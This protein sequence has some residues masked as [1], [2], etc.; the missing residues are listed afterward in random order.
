MATQKV[1]ARAIEPN[2]VPVTTKG[3]LVGHD[4][5]TPVRVPAG[6]PGLFLKYDPTEPS[7]IG[8]GTPPTAFLVGQLV[9]AFV[10]ATPAGFLPADGAE[11]SRSTYGTLFAAVTVQRSCNFTNSSPIVTGLSKTSDIRV[12]CSVESVG[13]GL[14]AARRVLT[15]D[16]AT[17]VTLDGPASLTVAGTMRFLP[18]GAG[19]GSTTFNVPDV[20]GRYLQGAGTGSAQWPVSSI[21]T[22]TDTFTVP[23]N[24]HL[25]TGTPIIYTSSGTAAGGLTNGVTYY[26]VR[27]STTTLKLATSVANAVAGTVVDI[28]T[29]GSGTQLLTAVLTARVMGQIGGEETHALTAGEM[30]AHVHSGA[31]VTGAGALVPTTGNLDIVGN[32]GSAG[33]SGAH[34]VL[35]PF[36]VCPVWVYTGV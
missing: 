24:L 3:D 21:N 22:G 10:F 15:V 36:L 9:P 7:G 25:Q 26:C 27:L 35:D 2:P 20:R 16:S 11:I 14:S 4:G 5:V 12:G 1:D 28:S 18:L 17:Q 19:N 34:G 6:T 32:S 8:S 33:G 29:G 23:A 30:P 13:S 31:V